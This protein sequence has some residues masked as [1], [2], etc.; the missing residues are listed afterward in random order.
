MDWLVSHQA[1]DVISLSWGEPDVGI[2]GAYSNACQIQCNA[3]TDGSYTLLHPV[4]EAAAA[5]GIGVFAASDDCGAAGGTSGVSP[6]FPS[7]DPYV[8]GVGGTVLSVGTTGSYSS[9]SGW[10]VNSSGAVSPGCV[11]QGGSGGGYSPYPRPSWQSALG[12]NGSTSGRGVPDVSM[13]A[14]PNQVSLV[15][16]NSSTGVGGTSVGSP[17]WAGIE[18]LAD[19]RLGIRLGSLNPVLYALARSPSYGPMFHDVTSGNN[20]YPAG[21]GWDPVTGLGTPIESVL[22]PGLVAPPTGSNGLRV[23][24]FGAPRLGPAP[25]PTE[26]R[27]AVTGGSAPYPFVDVYFGDGNASRV[28][29]SLWINHTY[30]SP[31]VFQAAV[32]VVDS[33]GNSSTSPP[34]SI[35]VG[36]GHELSVALNLSTATP[37]V[38]T[39]VTLGGNATNGTGPYQYSYYFG[40]GTY[41]L[42][43]TSLIVTHAYGAAGGYCATVVAVD[44]ATPPDGGSSGRV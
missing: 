12:I 39:P 36:G 17:M 37:S 24:L 33:T 23:D 5:E 31:G 18:A 11:N 9:E 4:L 2:Y 19:Q 41:D 22:V 8:T 35:V 42:N 26:F 34:L 32:T 10:S 28:P 14:G 43:R 27:I 40:D 16:G 6:D 29:P 38:G 30:P 15:L 13:V 1:A 25:L 44:S 3:T 7:S 20:G 21:T